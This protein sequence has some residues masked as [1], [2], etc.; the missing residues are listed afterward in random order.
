MNHRDKAGVVPSGEPRH[1]RIGE[2]ETPVGKR[3]KNG[4]TTR[5]ETRSQ[6][7]LDALKVTKNLSHVEDS[8]FTEKSNAP[9]FSPSYTPHISPRNDVHVQDYVA[10]REELT[11]DPIHTPQVV[12]STHQDLRATHAFDPGELTSDASNNCFLRPVNGSSTPRIPLGKNDG[13][14]NTFSSSPLVSSC[15]LAV[16][17]SLANATGVPDI[18]FRD[19]ADIDD[20]YPLD[21]DIADDDIIQLLDCTSGLVYENHIPPSSIQGWHHESQSPMDFDPT[22]QHTP[23]DP[24]HNNLKA[25][26]GV[27]VDALED[28][29]DEDVDW[30]AVL[31]NTNMIQQQAPTDSCLKTGVTGR[32]S[33]TRLAP[34]LRKPFPESISDRASVPGMS[35]D[36]ILR[37]CFR[38]GVMISQTVDCY[39]RQKDVVFELYARVTYSNREALTRKQHFQF[40]DLFKDQHP[41]PTATL[42]GWRPGSQLENDIS[43][44]L[45]THDGPRLSWCICKPVKDPKAAIGWTYTVLKIKEVDWEQIRWAKEVIC[46]YSNEQLEEMERQKLPMIATDIS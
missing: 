19:E 41:Y 26:E 9:I 11:S 44:F 36:T 14:Y 5:D 1:K 38:I 45:D 43:S 46:G 31:V 24:H 35:S 37:S 8:I 25:S 22:L 17:S 28:L 2:Y 15:T 10:V 4:S 33:V 27:E 29:L 18:N 32:I 40:I 21:E 7:S 30:N 34:F 20:T 23:P 39:R 6:S 3:H 42:T 13:S 12:S 16:D